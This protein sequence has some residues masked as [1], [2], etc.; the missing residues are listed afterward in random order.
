M[1]KEPL[2]LEFD[3]KTIKHL[4]ISLYSSL[5]PVIAE[6]VAN[7][8][9]ANAK[10]VTIYINDTPTKSIIIT[11]DGDGM[12]YE[13]LRTKYLEIGRD[14]RAEQ[15]KLNFGRQ[16]IGKKGIGKLSGFGIAKVLEIDT[17]CSTV[18]NTILLDYEKIINKK[19]GKYSPDIINDNRQ[20]DYKNGTTIKLNNL[21]RKTS[22]SQEYIENLAND[23]SKRFSLFD[24][25]FKVTLV[26]NNDENNKIPVSNEMKYDSV[27]AEF[28]W[29]LPNINFIDDYEFSSQVIGKII[30]TK[31]PA[32]KNLKGI[33]LLS[34][35]KL[36]NQK[37]FYDADNQDYAFTHLTGYLNVDFIEDFPED[38][39]STNRESLNWELEETINLRSFL[40]RLIT[41]I[42]DE[43]REKRKTEKLNLI[44][45]ES[46]IDVNE[47]I[48]SIHS[49]YEQQLA[50]KIIS[51][52]LNSS[53][54]DTSKAGEI[55]TYIR[56]S[57]EFE[58]FRHYAA[59][60]ASLEHI[61]SGALMSLLKEWEII[62][63]REIYHLAKV[64]IEAIKTFEKHIDKN[65]LEVKI[66]EP[67]FEK[68]PWILDP[69]IYNF[70][71]EQR[72]SKLLREKFPQNKV[73]LDSDKRI[74]FLCNNHIGHIFIIELKRPKSI[75]GSKQLQQG[76]EY[77]SFLEKKVGNEHQS[78]IKCIIVGGQESKMPADIKLADSL[79]NSGT[80]YFKSYEQILAQAKSYH[81]EIIEKYDKLNN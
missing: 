1:K 79:R 46:G 66:I 81:R 28:T 10:N 7:S 39:I 61:E 63:A 69:R 4:G 6:M 64:R 5:P 2:I 41:K 20:T 51:S 62:E 17:V 74:D 34:R 67:F 60:M 36:V 12:T 42:K 31:G 13:D 49:K 35:K 57:F 52:I 15:L 23:L 58:S 21:K 75:I 11:D 48:N 19:D 72:Y 43:W 16:P 70:K 56:N 22:F 59:E 44:K 53:N 47:W 8:F 26:Y 33:I 14:K 54:I 37:D 30:A 29:D 65:A 3:N 71:T 45:E 73:K 32:P 80:V 27:D 38:P 76:I 9:D 77:V 25:N 55:V 68:F 18:R 78:S 40:T 24:E 50:K